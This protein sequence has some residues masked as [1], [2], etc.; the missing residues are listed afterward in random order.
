MKKQSKKVNRLTFSSP[1]AVVVAYEQVTCDQTC[2]FFFCLNIREGG[3]DRRLAN[4]LPA[5]LETAPR[6]ATSGKVQNRKSAIHGLPF[7]KLDSLN[8]VIQRI[9]NENA[10]G[11]R[12][13]FKRSDQL[14]GSTISSISVDS[15]SLLIL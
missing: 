5:R 14:N 13:I 3:Y 12:R 4:R 10:A 9:A 7:T 11:I 1:E 15:S 2:F 6:I 8:T